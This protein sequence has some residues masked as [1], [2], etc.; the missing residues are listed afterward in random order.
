[1]AKNEN[2]SNVVINVKEIIIIQAKI[3]RILLKN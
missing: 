1:M 3:K 2:R